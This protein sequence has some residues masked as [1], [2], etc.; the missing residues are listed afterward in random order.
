MLTLLKPDPWVLDMGK[1]GSKD[2]SFFLWNMLKFGIRYLITM[3]HPQI[4]KNVFEEKKKNASQHLFSGSYIG[5][6]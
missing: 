1:I 5:Y 6:I 3:K 4:K 2:S